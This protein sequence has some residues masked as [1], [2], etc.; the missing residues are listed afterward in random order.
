[1]KDRQRERK[2]GNRKKGDT[3]ICKQRRIIY[4]GRLSKRGITRKHVYKQMKGETNK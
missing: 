1:M 4:K 3:K 2:L